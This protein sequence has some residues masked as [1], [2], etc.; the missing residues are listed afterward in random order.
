MN[1]RLS[2]RTGFQLDSVLVSDWFQTITH[3]RLL[4]LRAPISMEELTVA[5]WQMWITF[6]TIAVA[7]GFYAAGR[8]SMEL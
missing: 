5:S 3:A 1:H 4:I 2:Q 6:A 7:V 8:V